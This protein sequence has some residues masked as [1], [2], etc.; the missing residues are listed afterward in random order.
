MK[1]GWRLFV[2]IAAFYGLVTVIYGLW[3]KEVVGIVALILSTCLSLLIGFYFWF[4][5]RRLG[6]TLPEDNLQG[7]IAD[8]AGE[9]GFFSPHSWWPFVVALFASLTGLGLILGWWFTLIGASALMLA[10]MGWSLEYER[11]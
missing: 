4:T 8:R 5:D 1:F 2:G 11:R 9:Q 10:I 6:A 7:E 3:A